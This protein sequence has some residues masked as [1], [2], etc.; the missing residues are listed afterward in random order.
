MTDR[1]ERERERE[2]ERGRWAELDNYSRDK[3]CLHIYPHNS[4]LTMGAQ[5]YMYI[6]VAVSAQPKLLQCTDHITLKNSRENSPGLRA[7][8]GSTFSRAS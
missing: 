4:K 8:E 3:P 2:R 7:V 6:G 5:N 1:G